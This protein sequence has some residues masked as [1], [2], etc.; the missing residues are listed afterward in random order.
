MTVLIKQTAFTILLSVLTSLIGWTQTVFNVYN[1]GLTDFVLESGLTATI[2]GGYVSQTNDA[3]GVINNQSSIQLTGNWANN[4]VGA[5]NPFTLNEGTIEL[6]GTTEQTISGTVTTTFNNL[7]INNTAVSGG[8]TIAKTINISNTLTLTDGVVTASAGSPLVMDAGSSS[9]SGSFVSYVSGPMQKV[10]TTAFT[11][12][13]GDGG[14]WARL[15]IGTPSSV[16]TFEAEYINLGY[17]NTTSLATSPTPTLNNVS[18]IEHWNLT[19]QAGIGTVVVDI[20]WENASSS[21]I[22]DCTDLKLARWSGGAWEN[23]YN[24]SG[25]GVCSGTGSGFVSSGAEVSSFIGPLTFGSLVA[26]PTNPLPIELLSFNANLSDNIVELLWSTASEINNDYFTIEK[27]QDGKN[28]EIVNT[29]DGAGN[30]DGIKNYSAIDK[31][32]YAGFSYYRLKQTDFDGASSYSHIELIR[33]E[34]EVS[35]TLFPNPLTGNVFNIKMK[36]VEGQKV[37]IVLYNSMG[38]KVFSKNIIQQNGIMITSV[39]IASQLK[40]GIYVVVGRINSEINLFRQK[41]MIK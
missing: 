4:N 38:S 11:F 17:V 21:D 20:Y 22:T 29:I 25:S 18:T 35:V 28:F 36:G 10:G 16:T 33:Y 30:T 6:I 27:S 39:D 8:V 13:L 23:T 9:S 34:K 32:P 15:A 41:L 40:P 19:R 7:V 24:T 26:D 3:D 31:Y 37:E 5:A 2:L 1:D 12:P 14:V